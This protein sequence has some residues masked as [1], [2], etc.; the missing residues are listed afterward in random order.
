MCT[1]AIFRNI[2]PGPNCITCFLKG[3]AW[4]YITKDVNI[5]IFSWETTFDGNSFTPGRDA[6]TET[7]HVSIFRIYRVC[8]YNNCEY[9]LA[10]MSSIL[11]EWGDISKC[12]WQLMHQL[13][14]GILTV[15]LIIAISSMTVTLVIYIENFHQFI[16]I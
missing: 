8:T 13:L 5:P 14:K 11:F 6:P 7:E 10:V 9:T 16:Y 12:L 3:L 15:W 1:I 2:V 4:F